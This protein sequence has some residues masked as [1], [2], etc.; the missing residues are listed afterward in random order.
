MSHPALLPTPAPCPTGWLGRDSKRPRGC[1]SSLTW[2]PRLASPFTESSLLFKLL[3]QPTPVLVIVFFAFPSPKMT[4]LLF[5]GTR[6]GH[7]LSGKL[8]ETEMA[9]P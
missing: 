3:P 8:V 9:K 7:L 5:L 2:A 6:P 4:A 1:T